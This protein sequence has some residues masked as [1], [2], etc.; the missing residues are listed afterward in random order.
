MK[1]SQF[2]SPSDVAIEVQARDKS[3]LLKMLSSRAAL[4][5]KLPVG[6]VVSEIK[7][8]DELGSTG[9][10]GG[11]AIPHARFREVKKPFGL[12]VRLKRPIEFDAI[13]VQPVDIIF[14]LLLPASSQLDQLIALAA[15]ARRLRDPD[16]LRKLR[17]A[18][19][20]TDFYQAAM[21]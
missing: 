15:V 1:I 6:V 2:L 21:D 9:I 18:T 10:G 11:V 16:V 13:D 12:L 8:R 19:N 4:T 20:P 7:R 17:E 3:D 5:L 14:L